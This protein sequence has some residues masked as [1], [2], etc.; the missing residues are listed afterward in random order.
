[1]RDTV[2]SEDVAYRTAEGSNAMI[3][4]PNC[5]YDALEERSGV[6]SGDGAKGAPVIKRWLECSNCGFTEGL[7]K[8]LIPASRNPAVNNL[9]RTLVWGGLMSYG[10]A[11]GVFLGY[12]FARGWLALLLLAIPIIFAEI[13]YDNLKGRLFGS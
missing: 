7:V 2:R 4:C 6:V 9:V 12:T 10:L 1:L 11:L 8:P 5:G 3:R 13:L